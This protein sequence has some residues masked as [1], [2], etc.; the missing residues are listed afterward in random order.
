MG[1]P[2][3]GVVGFQLLQRHRL[4]VVDLHAG[5]QRPVHAGQR[6]PVGGGRLV[7]NMAVNV[8]CAR[9]ITV[10]GHHGVVAQNDRFSIHPKLRHRLDGDKGMLQQAGMG[11]AQPLHPDCVVI[12]HDQMLLPGQLREIGG[13]VL[14]G[15]H[16]IAQDVDRILRPDP[17]VPVV[18][19][20]T[21]HVL[22]TGEGTAAVPDDVGVTQVQVG[23]KVEHGKAPFRFRRRRNA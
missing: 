19:Q 23:G 16:E 20:T 10:P 6:G 7:V 3:G 8:V 12:A 2:K 11:L 9:K 5:I 21:V 4:V 18:D 14:T 22:H 13:R 1:L 17:A 15:E